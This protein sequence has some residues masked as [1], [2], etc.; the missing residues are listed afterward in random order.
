M[1]FYVIWMKYPVGSRKDIAAINSG[2]RR[3]HRIIIG[4]EQGTAARCFYPHTIQ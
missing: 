1:T 4:A 3:G 2:H